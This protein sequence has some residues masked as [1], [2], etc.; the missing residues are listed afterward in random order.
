MMDK[1]GIFE[2]YPDVQE[3]FLQRMLVAM[4]KTMNQQ[5]YENLVCTEV[6]KGLQKAINIFI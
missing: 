6:H 4:G 5:E 1:S 2:K 3:E